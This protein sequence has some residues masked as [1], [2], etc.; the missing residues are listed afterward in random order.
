MS[1]YASILERDL[2]KPAFRKR[3]QMFND[4]MK[5]KSKK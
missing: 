3:D 4:E 5:E 2:V 1:E